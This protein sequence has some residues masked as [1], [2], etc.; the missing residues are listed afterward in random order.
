MIER[1]FGEI[2]EQLTQRFRAAQAMTINKLIYLLEALLP[3]GGVAARQSHVT[4][5]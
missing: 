5:G 2:A 3:P 1:V 4:E